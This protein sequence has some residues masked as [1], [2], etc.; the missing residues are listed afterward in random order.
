MSAAGLSDADALWEERAEGHQGRRAAPGPIARAIDAYEQ[1]FEQQPENLEVR[2]K[3]LRALYFQGEYTIDGRDEKLAVYERGRELAEESRALLHRLA[4]VEA[5][6]G[7]DG[8][9]DPETIAAALRSERWAAE[10][11]YYAAVHWGL[12]GKTTGKMKAARQ[13]VGNKVRD[14][15][16]VVTLLDEGLESAG[17]LRFLGRLHTEAPKIPF[18]TGWID[19]DSAVTYLE[20]ACEL[21]PEHPDNQR[22]FADALLRFAPRRRAEGLE[23]LEALLNEDPRPAHVV[24]DLASLEA[25]R[26]LLAEHG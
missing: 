6:R 11:Y 18:I 19:H 7:A 3:L 23:R 5:G 2:W 1:V 25:A 8:K 15:A 14:F 16:T 4:G 9:D 12:W 20:R 22:F 21:A 17:G 26:A 13:G 24:E 10:I